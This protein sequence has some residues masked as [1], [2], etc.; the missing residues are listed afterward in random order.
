M[1][2]AAA[3]ASKADPAPGFSTADALQASPTS[4][5]AK[6][7]KSTTRLEQVKK[8]AQVV[9][10]IEARYPRPTGALGAQ[11]SRAID[12]EIAATL[13]HFVKGDATPTTEE[14]HEAVTA[15]ASRF[16]GKQLAVADGSAKR[17]EGKHPIEVEPRQRLARAMAGELTH[18]LRGVT[19][20]VEAFRSV[21]SYGDA[22]APKTAEQTGAVA[23]QADLGAHAGKLASVIW[24]LER[25]VKRGFELDFGEKLVVKNAEANIDIDPAAGLAA[26]EGLDKR[27]D[28]YQESVRDKAMVA[29]RTSQ[30]GGIEVVQV[31]NLDELCIEVEE[32]QEMELEQ[33]EPEQMEPEQMEPGQVIDFDEPI[34][35]MSPDQ[36]TPEQM[37]GIVIPGQRGRVAKTPKL[38]PEEVA[39]KIEAN[40]AAATKALGI[41][42]ASLPNDAQPSAKSR[43][44]GAMMGCAVG[45]C[46][47]ARMEFRSRDEIRFAEGMVT[48]LTGGGTFQWAPGEYTDDTQMA[49]AM[50]RS[51][52]EKGGFDQANVAEHFGGWLASSPK[53]VGGLTRRTLG[54]VLS[55]VS[56]KDAGFMPWAL[57]GYEN[58]GNGSV[59][60][61]A[62][63]ALLTA[64]RSQDEIISAA[65]DSSEITHADPR[66][67]WGTAAISLAVS[68]L[69]K[70][71]PD[72]RQ[73]VA[74]FLKDKSPELSAALD[75]VPTLAQDDLRTTGYVVD[76]VQAAF[77]ALEHT[78]NYVD[79]VAITAN[80]GD[81][82]DTVAATTGILLGARYGA[83]GIPESWSKKVQGG[84]ELR[85]LATDIYGLAK[86]E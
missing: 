18:R 31:P 21:S 22:L 59:M 14:R 26:L 37:E 74:A 60:R 75:A 45:D 15:V 28:D 7:G 69:I 68:M 16:L 12:H 76:T 53:D 10:S 2:L 81:D 23:F 4:P 42:K 52:V 83:E 5:L 3:T 6:A 19:T 61:A 48:D 41:L 40:M 82:T 49:A 78:D 32:E 77:W 33:M 63:V 17:L 70:G 29:R 67:T 73:K 1:A 30:V 13:R 80:N 20:E 72:V 8:T 24:N 64:Y 51:I 65:V 57:D 11:I 35:Q 55:G 34:Q 9:A 54:L 50:G 43:F 27:A 47:G 44:V 66:C 86:A 62:P 58:A 84:G 38:S 71:E 36:L 39:A 46:L 25:A 79:G 56:P 85:Q